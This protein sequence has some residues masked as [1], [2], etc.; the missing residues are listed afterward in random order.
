MKY[1]KYIRI[2][3]GEKFLTEHLF[4]KRDRMDQEMEQLL[5]EYIDGYASQEQKS[6]ITQRLAEDPLWQ[7]KYAELTAMHEVLLK[8]ELEMPSLR[9]TKNVMEEIAR[10]QVAPATRNY[11]NKNV[12][13]GIAAFFLIMIGGL[14]IYFVGQ[15]QWNGSS[16]N[17]LIPAYS[18][19]AGKLNWSR[20]LNNTYVNIFIGINVILGL[21]LIDKYLQRKKN[22]GHGG[23]W[24]GGD[25][26]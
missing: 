26:A 14:F 17:S 7:R 9:F 18:L 11:I 13:R 6:F 24:S 20:L 21:I 4:I 12:I 10:H 5:W 22:T 23:H 1:A 2:K 19:D 3:D 25:S 15:V 16:T 8:E